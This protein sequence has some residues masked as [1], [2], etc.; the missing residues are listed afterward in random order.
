MDPLLREIDSESPPLRDKDSE[1]PPYEDKGLFGISNLESL[2]L[3][4]RAWC[5]PRLSSQQQ[6]YFHLK[7][8]KRVTCLCECARC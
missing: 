7:N 6:T 4:S 8:K 5:F 2:S 3:S 1:S